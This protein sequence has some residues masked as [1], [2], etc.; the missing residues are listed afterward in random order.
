MFQMREIIPMETSSCGAR[1]GLLRTE[2]GRVLPI[3]Q[4]QEQSQVESEV[5]HEEDPREH[6]RDR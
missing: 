3:L 5:A 6:I 1:Q 4:L 2:E